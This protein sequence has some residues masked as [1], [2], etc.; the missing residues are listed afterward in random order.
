MDDETKSIK[1]AALEEASRNK[2]AQKTARIL[3]ESNSGFVVPNASQ[4]LLLLIE[5]AKRN[6]V[7]YGKSF[8]ILK[9][10]EDVK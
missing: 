9:L 6:V 1:K 8:D 4:K 10:S 5:L 7:I 2:T 3:L